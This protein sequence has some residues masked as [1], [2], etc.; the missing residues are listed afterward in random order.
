MQTAPS[1]Q[2]PT[3]DNHEQSAA[4]HGRIEVFRE[5]DFKLLQ[6]LMRYP[7]EE[8][9]REELKR[10]FDCPSEEISDRQLDTSMRRVVQKVSVLWPA[11]P[12]VKFEPADS[13]VYS[14]KAPKK[15]KDED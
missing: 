13:Y 15:K 1:L 14:E 4:L 11:Y 2:S 6:M 10:C 9:S 12:L 8:M 3:L 5:V 7:E